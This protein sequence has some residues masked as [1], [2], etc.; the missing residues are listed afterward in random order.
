MKGHDPALPSLRLRPETRTLRKSKGLPADGARRPPLRRYLDNHRSGNTTLATSWKTPGERPVSPIPDPGRR[1]SVLLSARLGPKNPI[2][3]SRPTRLPAIPS[4]RYQVWVNSTPVGYGTAAGDGEALVT[5]PASPGP[6]AS[7]ERPV[8][9][10]GTAAGHG[11]APVTG[12]ASPGPKASGER[13]VPRRAPPRASGGS[14]GVAP[15]DPI[16]PRSGGC[17]P[18][19]CAGPGGSRPCGKRASRRRRSR[20][21]SGW[22]ARAGNRRCAARPRCG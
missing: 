1:V 8:L 4:L 17:G 6:K 3:R 20:T 11:E 22:S 10:A 16:R 9:S 12:P 13:P 21:P 19:N 2:F 18:R 15:P 7:G 14:R 5:G